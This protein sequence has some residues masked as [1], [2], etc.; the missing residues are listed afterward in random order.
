[1]K[2]LPPSR[3]LTTTLL[4]VVAASVEAALAAGGVAYTKRHKTALLAEPSPLA[5]STGEL[6]FAQKLKIEEARGNWLRVSS[7]SIA[8]WVFTGSLSEG[9][10]E[11][12]KDINGGP[13]LASNT[14]ATAAARPL[15]PEATAY[16][17]RHNLVN[18]R[19]DLNWMISSSAKITATD[20]DKFLKEQKKGEYQ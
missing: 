12:L 11:E 14:T 16:A 15:G 17:A 5:K 6:G 18:A 4:L 19:E 7:G 13:L 9:K 8:G 10:P 3:L 20:V 2:K 1:M